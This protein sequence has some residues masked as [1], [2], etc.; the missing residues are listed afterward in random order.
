MAQDTRLSGS[1]FKRLFFAVPV[2]DAQ[3]RDLAAWRRGLA[4][5]NGKPVPA[6]N[7]HV[8]LLFLGDV[9]AALVPSI[10]A[11]V[12]QLARPGSA[13]RLLLDRLQ[14]WQK[15][16]A[17]VLEAQSTPP[18]LLHLVYGLQQALLPLGLQVI[19]RDY[20]PHLTLSRDYR[21]QPPEA[22]TAPDF[23]LLTREFVL[24]ESRK[25]AYTPLAR[26]SLAG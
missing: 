21:G 25:G 3:R 9:D 1:P 11:A 26:W 15:A 16:G 18:A 5:R 19:S 7:F 17:L 10:C 24:Y 23:Y 14:V 2:G 8:T 22:P 4:L 20:R 13:P 6:A 12:D